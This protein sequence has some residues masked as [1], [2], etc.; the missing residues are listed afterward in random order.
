M[1]ALQ[2]RQKEPGTHVPYRNSKLTL[3]L[4]DA[5]GARG[6]SDGSNPDPSP[7]LT[8]TPIPTP[9]LTLGAALTLAVALTLTRRARSSCASVTRLTS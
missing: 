2:S 7:N 3:L 4:S 1:L 9:S 5:L 8:L 6:V